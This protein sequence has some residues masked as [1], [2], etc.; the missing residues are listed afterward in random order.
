MPAVVQ[1]QDDP[2]PRVDTA[3]AQYQLLVVKASAKSRIDLH[4]DSE[5]SQT[6]L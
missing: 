4:C 5:G 6:D 3:I 2:V 1:L